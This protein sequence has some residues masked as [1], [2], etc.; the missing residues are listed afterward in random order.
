MKYRELSSQEVVVSQLQKSVYTK[1]LD[2]EK[3]CSFSEWG[4]LLKYDLLDI[5]RLLGTLQVIKKIP[6]TKK[7]KSTYTQFCTQNFVQI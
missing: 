6:I 5:C 2:P 1:R 4:H 3:K 7:K